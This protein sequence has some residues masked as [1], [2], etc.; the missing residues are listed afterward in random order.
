MAWHAKAAW[1][2]MDGRRTRRQV[3]WRIFRDARRAWPVGVF[4]LSAALLPAPAVAE[5]PVL[6][7]LGLPVACE[8]GRTCMIQNYFDHDPGAEAEDYACGDLVYDAHRGTDFRVP[9]LA[10]M[11]DGVPVVAAAAGRV[12]AVR[13]AMPDIDAQQVDRAAIEGR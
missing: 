10:A 13:D 9:D 8:I 5:E 3:A 4:A 11:A 7:P 2:F 1:S 6:P 12:R